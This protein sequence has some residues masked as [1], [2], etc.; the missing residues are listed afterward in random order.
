[1]PVDH[2]RSLVRTIPIEFKWNSGMAPIQ[3]KKNIFELHKN[4]RARGVDNLLEVSSKSESALGKCLSA[5]DLSFKTQGILTTVECAYQGSK[6]FEAGGPFIDL[7]GGDS[8]SAK[9]DV[10]LK[11]SGRLVSFRFQDD[12][13]P[14]WPQHIFYDWLYINALAQHDEVHSDLVQF[15]GFTDIEFN[16]SRSI[17]CQARSCAIFVSLLKRNQLGDALDSFREFYRYLEFGGQD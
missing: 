8:R 9:R 17:N 15:H 10:R 4:A 5:F 7:L 6:V 13:F 3:K 11:T 1:M 2:G 16:P 12:E 14:T